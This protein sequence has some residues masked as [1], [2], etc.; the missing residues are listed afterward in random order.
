M[1]LLSKLLLNYGFKAGYHK[2]RDLVINLSQNYIELLLAL[3]PCD[4]ISVVVW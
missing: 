1:D 2:T 4:I 3:L